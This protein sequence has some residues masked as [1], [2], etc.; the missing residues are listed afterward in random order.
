MGTGIESIH[1][2]GSAR[3][4][5]T[6]S[7]HGVLAARLTR[8]ILA[9]AGVVAVPAATLLALACP[10]LASPALAGPA[11]VSTAL[12]STALVSTAQAG[13]VSV[14]I[15][16][17]SPQTARPGDT[18]TVTGTVTN[19]TSQTQA[20]LVVYLMSSA[21]R[22][23][24][25]DQMDGYLSQ[26]GSPILEAVGNP[27]A[28]TPS[29]RPGA[30]TQ[31][32]ASFEVNN[33]GITQFGVY[34]ISAQLN[35]QA[36]AVLGTDQTL[37]PFW[38]GQQAAS[39]QRPLAIS[40][41]WPLIDQ[42]HHQVCTTASNTPVNALTS[43][44]L[45]ASLSPGGRLSDLLQAG[46]A[47]ADADL[48]W[49]VDPALLADAAAMTRP[50]RAGSGPG[51]LGLTTEP[52]S[53]AATTWL[54]GLRAVTSVQPT[55]ITPYANVDVSALVH[56]G[57]ET[58]LTRAYTTGR[59]VADDV[60]HGS[61]GPSIALPAG[62][63]ADLSVLTNLAA[64]QDINTVVLNSSQ[65]PPASTS[66]FEPDDAVTSVRAAGTTMTVLLADSVL[67][68]VLQAGGSSPGTP[69]TQFAVS[70]RFLAETAM[71]AAEAPDSDRS[72]VVEPPESWNPSAALAD[73]LLSETVNTPWLTPA[74]LGNLARTA[75]S[76]RGIAR[77]PLAGSAANPAELSPGYLEA[78]A[79]T[80]AS[81]STYESML[82]RPSA[83]Y[84][85]S[86]NEALTAAE[87]AAWRGGGG[88]QGI[89]LVDGLSAYL[90]DQTGKITII[91]APQVQMGGASGPVPV[92]IQNG[93]S[94][95]I[96]VKLVA[97]VINGPGRT[98]QLTIGHIQKP[99]TVQP[100]QAVTV[101]LPVSSAP[102]GSTEVKLSLTTANGTPL[103][104]RTVSFTILSTRYGRAIL[105][106]IAAAIGVLVLT[107]VYRAARRWL[108]ADPQVAT[109]NED[110]PGS[111][112]TSTA[113]ARPPTEKPDDL[114]DARRWVDD[115]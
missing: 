53:K 10:P 81:L 88:V 47:N 114:A 102:P 37:L 105:F 92:S 106:L 41:V 96:Q 49:V 111:V 75:D 23:T 31:W 38:P 65:L 22:F 48:T 12:V 94:L 62:G 32:H 52:A 29:L 8:R 112:V 55:V 80:E 2:T 97:G 1:S 30:T 45:A 84:L 59:T 110:L 73:E 113:G 27:F 63:T 82:Y 14:A 99:I 20:G 76:D 16:S 19:R 43:N 17:M 56:H 72:I 25:R 18:V 74:P 86:L 67:T 13:T 51:C 108:R 71:I 3:T 50:Y 115:A 77:H 61:F 9:L 79:A 44:A 60:L 93:S 21:A 85:Q 34:P 11:L 78:V 36:G 83:A 89:A 66:V 64:S 70:Q 68:N 7:V 15:D 87:S 26:S 6:S 57:L 69:A 95:P 28:I 54:A 107:S 90:A 33:V 39:L 46:Q 100:K 58:E 98:S 40:W 104:V 101:R 91:T 5:I 109:E 35:D 24:T 4:A 42:P 103:P